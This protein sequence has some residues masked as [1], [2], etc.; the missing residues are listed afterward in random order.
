MR[1]TGLVNSIIQ[2]LVF[3]PI[4]FN[5]GRRCGFSPTTVWRNLGYYMVVYLAACRRAAGPV[6]GLGRQHAS[7]TVALPSAL[8]GHHFVLTISLIT[9]GKLFIQPYIMTNG[10]RSSTTIR[11]SSS[12][13]TRS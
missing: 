10:G 9:S 1:A 4:L 8:R 11:W 5:G 6:R 12:S 13:A 3:A 2:T 7:P